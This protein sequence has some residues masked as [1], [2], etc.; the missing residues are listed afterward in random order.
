LFRIARLWN[1]A[2]MVDSR[3]NYLPRHVSGRIAVA[4]ICAGPHCLIAEINSEQI[5]SGA[6]ALGVGVVMRIAVAGWNKS[7]LGIARLAV[8][9]GGSQV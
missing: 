8:S 3:S 2:P 5:K 9:T 1:D 4:G 6:S 7:G